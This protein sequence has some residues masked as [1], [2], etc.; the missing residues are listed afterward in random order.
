MT[1]IAIELVIYSDPCQFLGIYVDGSELGQRTRCFFRVE[2]N[3]II[4]YTHI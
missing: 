4:D 3:K 1:E 2:L